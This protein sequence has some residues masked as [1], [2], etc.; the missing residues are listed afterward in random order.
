MEYSNIVSMKT[1]QP[2]DDELK[3]G[4]SLVVNDKLTRDEVSRVLAYQHEK[5]LMFGEAAKQ[6][7]LIQEHDLQHVLSEQFNYAYIHEQSQ[8]AESNLQATKISKKLI[9]AHA[10]FSQEVER[11]RSLRSQLQ[12]RWF[13]HGNKILAIASTDKE[14]HASTLVANLAIVF[15]QLNKKTLLIDAN[16]RDASHNQL[17]GIESKLGLS[18]IL[19]NRQ[20]RYQL[21]KNSALPNLSILTAGT[22]VPNPQELLGQASFG[23]LLLDLEKLYD[24]ILIDTSPFNLGLDVLNIAAKAKAVLLVVRKDYSSQAE[25]KSLC[26][27]LNFTNA[28]IVGSV[29]QE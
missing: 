27:Q 25:L 3:I 21:A 9:A 4:E 22:D 15:S 16:L 5:G 24:V 7:G 10:P 29:F 1:E 13:D 20:G 18:N 14:E 19:A 12:M 8:N 26:H 11:L 23:E 6:L 28:T 17:F 2:I